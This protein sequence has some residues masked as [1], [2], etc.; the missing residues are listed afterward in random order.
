MPFS[1][2]ACPCTSCTESCPLDLMWSMWKNI[3]GISISFEQYGLWL[4]GRSLVEF[5][6][7][8]LPQL[9]G[10]LAHGHVSLCWLILGW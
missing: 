8:V 10:D 2:I 9:S 3:L 5:L 7:V 4:L 1:Y 6:T